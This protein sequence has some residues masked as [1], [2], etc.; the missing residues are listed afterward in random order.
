M[1]RLQLRH[2]W[3]N[4]ARR[5]PLASHLDFRF[6]YLVFWLQG[7]AQPTRQLSLPVSTTGDPLVV[8]DGGTVVQGLTLGLEG[9]W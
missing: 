6:G 4:S 8:Q 3:V 1:T 2:S 7:L 9:H 5:A